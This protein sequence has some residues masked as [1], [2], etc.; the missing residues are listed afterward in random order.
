M[1][2]GNSPAQVAR[3]FLYL[4]AMENRALTPMQLQ[5][6]VY[7]AHGWQLGL[8]GRP[9]VNEP[10]EAWQYGPV[11]RSLYQEYKRYGSRPIDQ[12]VP[13]KP[14]GFDAAEENTIEQVWRG[15]GSR[16]GVSLSALTHEPGSPWSITVEKLG[17][18]NEIS[19]DIIEDH[20]KRRAAQA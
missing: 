9:L 16:T 7:I 1:R 2:N 6:L 11:I 13:I 3:Y 15:Y 18:N 12:E 17:L 20:Y 19:N 8:Y 5:K 4:S 10:V 14:E